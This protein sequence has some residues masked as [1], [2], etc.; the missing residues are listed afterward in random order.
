M[1]FEGHCI[2]KSNANIMNNIFEDT[3]SFISNNLYTTNFKNENIENEF[4]RFSHFSNF[5]KFKKVLIFLL[6]T[7]NYLAFIY[8]FINEDINSNFF[9]I[10]ILGEII[11]LIWFIFLRKNNKKFNQILKYINFILFLIISCFLF[12]LRL[13]ISKNQLI[14][15]N[16]DAILDNQV[17][18]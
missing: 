13:T 11:N 3:T 18:D 4:R 16:L 15:E 1:N 2:K 12:I 9:I 5:E 8:E 10:H 14:K 17:Y 7:L 6:F